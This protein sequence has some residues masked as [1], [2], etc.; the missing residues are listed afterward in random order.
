MEVASKRQHLHHVSLKVAA[1]GDVN[2]N[3]MSKRNDLK[4]AWRA[5]HANQSKQQMSKMN[6][7]GVTNS[8]HLFNY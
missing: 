2:K 7:L 8:K 4:A 1:R 5:I 3:K 6:H